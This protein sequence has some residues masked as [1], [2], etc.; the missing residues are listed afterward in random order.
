ML[1]LK[2]NF[3]S[4]VVSLKINLLDDLW[5]LS[6]IILPGDL[7]TSKTERKIKIGDDSSGNVRII[8][9][10]IVLT[11]QVESVSLDSDILR[12]KGLTATNSDDVPKGSYHSFGLCLGDSFTLK[13]SSW[14][15]FLRKQLSDAIKNNS[16]SFL[17]VIFDREQAFF[18]K[19]SQTGISHISKIS[20][21]VQ[22]KQFQSS[23]SSSIYKLI[24]SE[25]E[26]LFSQ[27]D[28]TSIVFASPSFWQSSLESLLSSHLKKKSVFITSN[29]VDFSVV[30]KLLSRPELKSLLS[31]QRLSQEQSFVDLAL[32]KLS[33]D[34]LVYGFDDVKEA[35]I[36]GAISQLGVSDSFIKKSQEE[37]FYSEL[38][39]IMKTVD[40]NTGV[41][42]II[43]SK[44]LVRTLDGLG[45]IVGVLR[46][47][48]I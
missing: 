13:K 1:S 47:K 8:R 16:Q 18:S 45:G 48:T 24:I 30:S 44:N 21:D 20:A 42:H 22:K 14:P 26:K 41:V 40:K 32:E 11:L 35:A 7:I 15:S 46:W 34:K 38:D 36:S 19:I 27:Q 37:N 23:S 12:V 25:L 3:K 39:S 28:F 17:M 6:H 29:I 9:K 4:G 2:Q 10:T 33:K 43:Q 5:Y 31:D